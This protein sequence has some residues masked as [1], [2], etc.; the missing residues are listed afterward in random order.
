MGR[1][2]LGDKVSLSH[3]QRAMGRDIEPRETAPG[4]NPHADH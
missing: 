3:L 1:N 4:Y 2:A